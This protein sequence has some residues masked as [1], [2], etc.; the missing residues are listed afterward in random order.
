MRR[1]VTTSPVSCIIGVGFL[2]SIGLVISLLLASYLGQPFSETLSFRIDDGWCDKSSEGV[3]VHCFGDFGTARTADFREPIYE[4][5]SVSASNTPFTLFI[6]SIFRSIP[7]QLGVLMYLISLFGGVV[8]TV[9]VATKRL[10]FTERAALSM[11]IGVLNVGVI[12]AVDRGNHVAWLVPISYVY[13]RSVQQNRWSSAVIPLA[14]LAS[15][16]FW[17]ILFIIP[18]LVHKKWRES[19]QAIGITV[20]INHICIGFYQG[21]YVSKIAGMLNA[22]L[23]RDFA[24]GVANYSV[25]L[26]TLLDR[27]RCLAVGSAVCDFSAASANGLS[28]TGLKVLITAVLICAIYWIG[29]KLIESPI[30]FLPLIPLLPILVLP[31]SAMYN[32]VLTTTSLS[33]IAA[34]HHTQNKSGVPH[35]YL[36]WINI[37][38]VLMTLMIVPV[39]YYHRYATSLGGVTSD[40]PFLRLQYISVPILA[41][42]IVFASIYFVSRMRPLASAEIP[43]PLTH[44]T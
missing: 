15:L 44:K 22:T 42:S 9:W 7:Y 35:N 33:L 38:A 36:T 6:W 30:L 1:Q 20:A 11:S 26:I 5:P 24:A 3:G 43:K 41:A 31:E 25:G 2:G 34:S 23:S 32:I 14:L 13:L 27:L 39:G 21:S 19:A 37:L 28:A 29:V 12:S 4:T 17:G 16:K 18:L 10:P 40:G 8:G